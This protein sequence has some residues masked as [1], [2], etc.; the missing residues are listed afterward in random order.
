MGID[1]GNLE[2]AVAVQGAVVRVLVLKV[3]GSAPREAGASMIVWEGGQDGTIGGGTLEWDAAAEAREMLTLGPWARKQRD[4]ALGPELGQCCGGRV[5]LL[6]ERY[7]FAEIAEINRGASGFVRP[8]ADGVG[9]EQTPKA[10]GEAIVEAFTDAA[11]PVYL[12][13]A[14]HVGRE[15][16]RVL[17]VS[18]FAIT[19]VDVAE[20]RFPENLFGAVK[21]VHS[22]PAA[23][24]S[25]APDNAFH[26]V[27]T[28]SH[29]HD[30]EICNRVLSRPFG[31]LGLIGS[32]T[33][34]ARFLKRLAELGH[35][36]AWARLQCP[37]GD[38][39]LGKTPQAIAIGVAHW[40]MRRK[41]ELK[42]PKGEGLI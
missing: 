24:V 17:P 12:Y 4:I 25:T 32:A 28:H 30:L 39:S 33:K 16:V 13:G 18:D 22:N 10:Q 34:K 6:F 29:S 35:D 27:M 36:T 31:H 38:R 5:E 14:G 2:Q 26:F 40:L 41:I 9:P 7:T 21:A 15:L 1:L 8:I 20:A 11:L 19:W 37:I 23:A 42:E 3:H